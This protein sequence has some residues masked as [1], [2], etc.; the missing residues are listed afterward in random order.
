MTA[1]QDLFE[2]HRLIERV[3][4]AMETFA[5]QMCGDRDEERACLLRLV[6]FF[7]EYA[8][9]RHHA[10]E[11]EIL[12][13][14]LTEAGCRW[15]EGLLLTIRKEHDFERHLLQTLRHLSLQVGDWSAEDCRRL[16]DVAQRFVKFM[17]SHIALEDR[18]LQRLVTE[19]LSDAERD[20]LETKLQHFDD[21]RE[22]QGETALLV[23]LGHELIARFSVAQ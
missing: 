5:G 12:M 3:V 21:R 22:L 18:D 14:A 23:N 20:R 10:K 16:R 2:E 4:F 19:R 13:P 11:E 15:D 7:R 9:L 6:T 8:D 17:R 1:V